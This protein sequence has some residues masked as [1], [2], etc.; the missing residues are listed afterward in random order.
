[1]AMPRVDAQIIAED[2]DYCLAT[3]RQTALALWVGPPTVDQVKRISAQC[4]LLLANGKGPVTYLGVIERSSP[5]PTDPVRKEFAIWSRDVVSK[6]SM[7]VMVAEGGGFRAALVRG[8]GIAL[9]VLLPHQVPFKFVGSVEEGL[10]L[11]GRV[12]PPGATPAELGVA[13]AELRR[14]WAASV[15]RSPT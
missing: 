4:K 2:S 7:A 13:I 14:R 9:T 10:D 12:L 5:A 8:V 11:M 15:R 3:W 6:L 1:M